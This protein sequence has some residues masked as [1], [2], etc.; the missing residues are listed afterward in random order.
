MTWLGSFQSAL[1]SFAIIACSSLTGAWLGI[2]AK[3]IFGKQ[4]CQEV[5]PVV[6]RL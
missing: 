5:R 2:P 3:S 4:L 6:P 1:A